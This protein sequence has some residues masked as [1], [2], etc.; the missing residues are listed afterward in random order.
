MCC[1]CSGN[2]NSSHFIIILRTVDK[3][4]FRNKELYL[5]LKSIQRQTCGLNINDNT[6]DDAA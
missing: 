5:I 1:Y 4:L 3:M 6:E 2:C